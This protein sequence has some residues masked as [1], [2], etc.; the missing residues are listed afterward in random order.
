MH[1]IVICASIYHEDNYKCVAVQVHW[2]LQICNHCLL[3]VVYVDGIIADPK[4]YQQF[5][6]I[7]DL[8]IKIYPRCN[9]YELFVH[10]V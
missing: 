8:P 5:V 7:L 1:Y 9:L 4:P 2:I 6:I 3:N 10:V